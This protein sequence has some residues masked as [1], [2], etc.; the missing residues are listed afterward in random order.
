MVLGDLLLGIFGVD[1]GR[2]A[3][4]SDLERVLR[5]TDGQGDDFGAPAVLL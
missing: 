3:L 1:H 2:M 4:C 5:S